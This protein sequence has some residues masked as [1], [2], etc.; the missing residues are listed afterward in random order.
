MS[1]Q[2]NADRYLTKRFPYGATG[3][4]YFVRPA[5]NDNNDGL[6]AGTA[7]ATLER[8]LHF[9]AIAEVN[10]S[11]TLNI[12]GMTIT[13][14]EVLNLGGTTLGGVNFGVDATVVPP[15][16]LKFAKNHRQIV[17]DLVLVQALTITG[18]AQDATTGLLTLTVNNA[19][20]ANALNGKFAVSATL[21]EYGT[22]KSH[23]AG[24][25]PNTIVVACATTFA[26]VAGA[27]AYQPGATLTYGDPADSF[28]GAIYLLALCDWNLQGL[29]IS[30]GNSKAAA[31]TVWPDAPVNLRF[32]DLEGL[33]T[34]AGSGIV[35]VECCHVHDRSW[36]QNGSSIYC[37]QTVIR[38]IDFLCHGAGSS[39]LNE[40]VASMITASDPYGSGNVESRFS[41]SMIQCQVDLAPDQ[42]VHANFGVSRLQLCKVLNNAKSGI[43]AFN[44]VTLFLD[45]VQGTANTGFGVDASY[46]A[47]VI[48]SGGTA[49][50][51]TANDVKVGAA[52]NT[53]WAA[54]AAAPV[55][56]ADQLVRVGA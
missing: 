14:A 2:Q 39:G 5:G 9:M 17:S 11:V 16:N 20:V 13:A 18:Q 44:H 49:V 23:T 26:V 56:D 54:I 29:F 30:S 19:L 51:G 25:A 50:T 27:G 38:S 45:N 1:K 8:A 55:T 24:A 22:I 7:F 53:T 42:G 6:T 35:N 37:T 36:I 48:P 4:V 41:F 33:Q 46:G 40:M 10:E 52:G 12:T 21:G 3:L 43:L 32:C 28:E 31:L 47:I 34:E 15:A